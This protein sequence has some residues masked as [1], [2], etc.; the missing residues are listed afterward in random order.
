M[1][2]VFQEGDLEITI[3]N[4]EEARKFDEQSAPK[5]EWANEGCGLCG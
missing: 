2:W 5:P 1:T 4:A 3:N